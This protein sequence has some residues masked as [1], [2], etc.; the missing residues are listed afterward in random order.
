MTSD[1]PCNTRI[2][3]DETGQKSWKSVTTELTPYGETLRETVVNR[4][5]S[6]I[7]SELATPD[8][9]VEWTRYHVV[10]LADGTVTIF[11]NY[12]SE[13]TIHDADGRCLAKTM[14]TA[15]GPEPVPFRGEEVS[16]GAKP[17]SKS[18]MQAA[19]MLYNW[20]ASRDRADDDD[21]VTVF[22]FSMGSFQPE[23]NKIRSRRG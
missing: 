7:R 19:V 11:K 12:G 8:R 20:L 16:G 6:T 22:A 1:P 10:S 18:T 17:L 14:W 5:G 2:V 4:D 9:A 21:K 3:R 13:Q 15:H 23:S